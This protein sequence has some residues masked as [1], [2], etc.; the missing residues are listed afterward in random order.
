MGADGA[1][2]I[3]ESL[4]VNTT[5]RELYLWYNSVGADGAR[6]LRVNSTL[7]KLVLGSNDVGAAG[8]RAIADALGVNSTL[9]KLDLSYNRDVSADGKKALRK[10][11]N[12]RKGILKI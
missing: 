7:Q 9:Q 8:A 4:R 5:L 12:N 1:R 3:A 2:A 11:W 6:A 10:S